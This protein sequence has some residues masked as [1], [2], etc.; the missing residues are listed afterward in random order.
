MRTLNISISDL[1]FDKFGLKEDK[2]SFSDFVDL[3]SRELIRQN[4][5]KCVELADKYGLS[6]LTMDQITEEVK[7]VRQNAKN[8]N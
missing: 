1:E 3:I 7:A 2:L 6:K 8:R 5:N 4:L